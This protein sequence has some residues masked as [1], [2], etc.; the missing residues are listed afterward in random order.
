MEK[1]LIDFFLRVLIFIV[2]ILF[3]IMDNE[4]YL[5]QEYQAELEADKIRLAKEYAEMLA[6]KEQCK[7]FDCIID[8]ESH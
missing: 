2:V 4:L 3:L 1:R 5:S 6:R 7:T 8:I